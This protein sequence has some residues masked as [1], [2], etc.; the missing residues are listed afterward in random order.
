MILVLVEKKSD[1]FKCTT[2]LK[3]EDKLAISFIV[4]CLLGKSRLKLENIYS[5][6]LKFSFNII[7]RA[8]LRRSFLKYHGAYDPEKLFVDEFHFFNE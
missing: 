3:F 4:H 5:N 6:S 2:S 7:L 1:I 8:I